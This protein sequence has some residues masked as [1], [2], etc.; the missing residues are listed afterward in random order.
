MPRDP[1]IAAAAEMRAAQLA[2]NEAV[3]R[4]GA[5]AVEQHRTTLDALVPTTRDGALRKLVEI[6]EFAGCVPDDAAK[7]VRR[8]VVQ[9]LR[10]LM[11]YRPRPGDGHILRRAILHAAPLAP[12]VRAPLV[13]SIA[14][15]AEWFQ[16]CDQA[17]SDAKPAGDPA[18]FTIDALSAELRVNRRSIERAIDAGAIVPTS[19]TASGRARFSVEYVECLKARAAAARALGHKYLMGSIGVPV[20]RPRRNAAQF[21]EQT[22]WKWRHLHRRAVP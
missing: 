4:R 18:P 8:I 22:L 14:G 1:V 16:N 11:R 21:V 15:V 19:R 3:A 10:E 13:Q 7:K 9:V 6:A 2:P 20:E 17:G 5:T 12:E